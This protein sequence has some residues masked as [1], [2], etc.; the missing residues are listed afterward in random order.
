MK[1]IAC[2]HWLEDL[3]LF[4]I[5]VLS[6]MI[7][8]F[9]IIS[10]NSKDVFAKKWQAVSKNHRKDKS[11]TINQTTL[12]NKDGKLKLSSF[13]II[14][15]LQNYK[16]LLEMG[17]ENLFSYYDGKISQY[18]VKSEIIKE[19]KTRNWTLS[20]LTRYTLEKIQ[21]NENM[22]QIQEKILAKH[23]KYRACILTRW[24]N[25]QNQ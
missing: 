1:K 10:T 6:K 15:N 19:K 16:I 7:Y 4:K 8:R 3:L 12:K 17:G 25:S 21:G 20:K 14:I 2:V 22:R 5:T 23:I 18:D 24:E 9:N 13:K 11:P